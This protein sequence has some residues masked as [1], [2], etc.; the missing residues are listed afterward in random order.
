MDPERLLRLP[1][2][3]FWASTRHVDRLRASDDLRQLNILL[4]A[5]MTAQGGDQQF[6]NEIRQGLLEQ[7]GTVMRVEQ[8]ASSKSEVMALLREANGR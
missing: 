1:L 7:M 8:Q 6:L 2:R 5:T 3:L 4:A